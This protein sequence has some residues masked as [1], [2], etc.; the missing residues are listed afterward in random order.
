MI[1][2]TDIAKTKIKE[3][4]DEEGLE[5]SVRVSINSGGCAGFKHGMDFDNLIRETDEILS[6]NEIQVLIDP[7]SAQY[8][9][10]TV[11]DFVEN[12]FQSGFSF[13]NPNVSG[14][15][16]CKESVSF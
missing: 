2:L 10:D 1:F 15:C 6:V 7:I 4:A 9:E 11:V 16:G 13:S 5:Y 8:L 12:Q 14:S 3:I